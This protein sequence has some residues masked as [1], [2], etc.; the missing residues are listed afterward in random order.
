MDAK[1]LAL[2]FP[3]MKA[4][5]LKPR[6][7]VARQRIAIII[8][9]RNRYPHLHILL[10]NLIPFLT[11]QQVDATFFVI[12]QAMPETFNR[13]ALLNVGFL[14]A[15]KMHQFD[16]YIFHDVDLIPLNDRHLYRC[17]DDP[18]H[19]AVAMN[20]YKFKLPYKDYFGGA[21]GFSRRQFL[22]INGCSNVFFGWGGE[23]DE[24]KERVLNKGYTI[25]RS[26]VAIARYDMI[27]HSRD[28]G[29]EANPVR[30]RILSSTKARQEVEGLNTIIYKVN[31]VKLENFYIWINVTLNRTDILRGK[32]KGGKKEIKEKG[33]KEKEK[34]KEKGRKKKERKKGKKRKKEKEEEEEEEEEKKGKKK[35]KKEE[36]EEE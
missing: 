32:K 30:K 19:F 9:Y 33:R 13:G 28:K 18:K 16:C 25:N 26:P 31:S 17:G 11:R 20:K 12:E 1:R 3:D 15:D 35:K 14:E 22:D 6:D 24:L 4:A 27:K 29:N 23:D 5:R 2:A 8:P 21:V 7:C 34:E 10:H 36:E